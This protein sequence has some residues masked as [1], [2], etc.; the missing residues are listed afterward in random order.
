MTAPYATMV[1]GPDVDATGPSAERL[2]TSRVAGHRVPAS[3]ESAARCAGARAAH[4][5]A[6]KSTDV[7]SAA[8]AAQLSVSL[9]I[10][11]EA[12]ASS[13]APVSKPARR[14]PQ[15]PGH[16]RA[17]PSE[18]SESFWCSVLPSLCLSATAIGT[19][20]HTHEHP[21][22]P[23][24]RGPHAERADRMRN[25]TTRHLKPARQH[26]SS[27]ASHY[28]SP[29]TFSTTTPTCFRRCRSTRATH[30]RSVVQGRV[31]STRL[32]ANQR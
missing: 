10:G 1:V 19:S 31:A 22:S 7:E 26:Q 20:R 5:E 18:G 12:L 28:S 32:L 24:H 3:D 13:L 4:R 8:R 9:A 29:T 2:A 14:L 15:H 27:L 21:A 11:G 16:L 17:P 25:R 6:K 23:G 30:P